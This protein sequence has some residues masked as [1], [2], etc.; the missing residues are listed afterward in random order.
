MTDA[1]LETYNC[2]K[3]GQ[4]STFIERSEDTGLFYYE[5]RVGR[6][7]LYKEDIIF[8]YIFLVLSKMNFDNIIKMIKSFDF[9]SNNE[10][11][12]SSL[13]ISQEKSFTRA[14]VFGDFYIQE[15]CRNNSVEELIKMHPD[16]IKFMTKKNVELGDDFVPNLDN[17]DFK[18]RI[19]YNT[20]TSLD[21]KDPNVIAFL[22]NLRSNKIFRFINRVTY[23]NPNFPLRID[24]SITKFAKALNGVSIEQCKLFNSQESYEVEIEI[25]NDLCNKFDDEYLYKKTQQCIKY[26]LYGIQESFYP[27]SI[28]K[29]NDVIDEYK[30]VIKTLFTKD[31]P[32]IFTLLTE[33]S[34]YY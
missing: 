29:F 34:I 1:I 17:N 31:I 8:L 19:A 25:D 16:N 9:T 7:I 20:E 12:I 30:N 21:Y 22:S 33:K 3:C 13:K 32:I 18:F 2:K 26:I 23:T 24:C 28:Q 10:N 14:E 6:K 5:K 15:Y 4:C 27:I 11:G